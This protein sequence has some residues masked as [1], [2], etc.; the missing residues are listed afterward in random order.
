MNKTLQE[1]IYPDWWNKENQLSS[2]RNKKAKKNI[3]R[4]A[5]VEVSH[6]TP[7]VTEISH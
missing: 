7:K 5:S 3:K 4:N 2:N 6:V 1:I